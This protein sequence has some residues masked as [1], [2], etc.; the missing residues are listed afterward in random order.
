MSAGLFTASRVRVRV[1]R[2]T[3]A[4]VDNPQPA[5]IAPKKPLGTVLTSGATSHYPPGTNPAEGEHIRVMPPGSSAVPELDK[6]GYWVQHNKHGQPIDPSTG[7]P[8]KGR[9][10]THVPRPPPAPPEEKKAD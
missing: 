1:K 4:A 10:D 3:R 9:G 6:N 2:R 8:G 7:K 5:G